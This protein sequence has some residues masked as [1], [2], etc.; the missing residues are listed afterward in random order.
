M[1]LFRNAAVLLAASVLASALGCTSSP[2]EPSSPP[3]TSKPPVPQT[4]Y[5]ITVTANP[6]NITA[7]S[8]GS[9]AIT[10]EVRQND[11]GQPPPDG[12]QVTLNTTLGS[13]NSA[14]SGQQTVT[15]GLVNGRAQAALFSGTDVGTATV[16][17]SFGGSTG[18]ANVHINSAATFFVSSVSPNTGDA[19]GGQQVTI[20]G[21]GFSSPVR[22][23]FGGAAATVRSVTSSQIV[24]VTPSAAA[25]GAPVGVG[26]S[27]SVS[28]MVTNHVNQV[29]QQSDSIDRGFTYSLGGGGGGGQPAVFAINPA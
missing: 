1:R 4:T 5:S 8:G 16:T 18:A 9:S 29:D 15:L 3:V 20:L 22:V 26:E 28:V 21:G 23:T 6:P 25:A 12:S 19:A 17:A 24:V 10:V 13:F 27:A 11:T 2:T 7:G 14:S